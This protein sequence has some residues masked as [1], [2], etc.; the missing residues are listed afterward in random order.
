LPLVKSQFAPRSITLAQATGS[1]TGVGDIVLRTK[2]QVWGDETGGAALGLNLQLPTGEVRD[3]HGTDET[4]VSTFVYLSQ[5]LGKRLE[6]HLNV[7]VDFNADE[8]DRSSF[9][10]AVGATLLVGTQLGLVVD[11][12]GYSE[13]GRIS[14]SKPTI[15]GRVS[16]R[17]PGSCTVEHPC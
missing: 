11:F 9:L 2:Y 14:V 17:P 7:G 3:F 6:P 8:M 15:Q 10:W 12:V 5:V 13:F 16:N 1:A 4:H